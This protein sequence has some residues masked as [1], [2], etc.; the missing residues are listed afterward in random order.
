LTRSVT[1]K[2]NRGNIHEKINAEFKK[3]GIDAELQIYDV[4]QRLNEDLIKIKRR[5][6]YKNEK[7]KH[8]NSYLALDD[9]KN[10]D[11]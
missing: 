6:A 8:F 5:I 1:R 2:E 9:I 4:M 10:D 7:Y 11:E 3:K